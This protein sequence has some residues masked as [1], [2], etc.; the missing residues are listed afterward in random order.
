MALDLGTLTLKLSA[1]VK[2]IKK[3]LQTVAQD[4][5]AA[6][7][8]WSKHWDMMGG[9]LGRV[10]EKLNR[11]SEGWNKA[12]GP[13]ATVGMQKVGNEL[14]KSLGLTQQQVEGF[15]DLSKAFG[16]LLTAA[17][18]LFSFLTPEMTL[19]LGM[20]FAITMAWYEMDKAFPQLTQSIRT[21]VSSTTTWL[22]NMWERM[23]DGVKL[24]R[25]EGDEAERLGVEYGKK[26]GADESFLSPTKNPNYR[27]PLDGST[28][29][30]A[31]LKQSAEG[32]L[33]IWKDGLGKVKE[34]IEAALGTKG[35]AL[36]DFSKSGRK[37]KSGGAAM[38]V[39]DEWGLDVT[40]EGMKKYEFA[41]VDAMMAAFESE[42]DYYDQK[43]EYLDRAAET[44]ANVDEA[45]RRFEEEKLDR[46]SRG[47]LFN[48][49]KYESKI[50]QSLANAANVLTSAIVQQAPTFAATLSAG[51]QGFQSG[52][53][54]GAII[55][56]IAA[57]LSHAPALM[58][59]AQI[60]EKV[61]LNILDAVAPLLE[62]VF[63]IVE[64]LAPVFEFTAKVIKGVV[65]LIMGV[66]L[67]IA[68]IVDWVTGKIAWLWGGKGTHWADAIERAKV[69][70][71]QDKLAANTEKAAEAVQS[72][73][74]A[75]TNVPQGFKIEAARFAASSNSFSNTT[76]VNVAGNSNSA[77]GA[78]ALADEIDKTQRMARTGSPYATG[79]SNW[80]VA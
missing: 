14:A 41:H 6:A 56:A 2:D 17:G 67:G 16:G 59:I 36:S 54:W 78:R 73:A 23:I 44:D 28:G 51:I 40:D 64:G 7:A 19:F 30:G 61:T 46:L 57:L 5:R 48:P 45:T 20:V 60:L 43:I 47:M 53:I 66:A 9:S 8:G 34:A 15:Q 42:G 37:Q 39:S 49:A 27:G 75:L 21:M 18:T 63:V 38:K 71:A 32:A 70:G 35:I 11:I 68:K 4:T 13:N 72:F 65:D 22:S 55:A 69:L 31:S 62:L 24:M 79:G 74:S 77:S 3:G 52:G 25:A 33:N 29:V 10:G 58:R 50:G 80:K 76:V 26:W 1:D 12:F